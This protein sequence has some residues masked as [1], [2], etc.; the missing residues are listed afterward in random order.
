MGYSQQEAA[1]L[2][3]VNHRRISI[4]ERGVEMPSGDYLLRLVMIYHTHVEQLY[5]EHMEP[6]L[7]AL[8]LLE[9]KLREAKTKNINENER[10]IPINN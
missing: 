4:W 10:T 1:S 3:G 8:P 9:Q 7:Y 2:V 6:F 5:H